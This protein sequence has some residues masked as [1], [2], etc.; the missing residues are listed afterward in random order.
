MVEYLENDMMILSSCVYAKHALTLL[1]NSVV[2]D[3]YGK[4]LVSYI[5]ND[6]P[7]ALNDISA[8]I[9]VAMSGSPPKSIFIITDFDADLI[10]ST[11]HKNIFSSKVKP[12]V[13]FLP[14]TARVGQLQKMLREAKTSIYEFEVGNDNI[15]MTRSEL[16][17]LQIFFSGDRNAIKDEYRSIKTFYSQK[18]SGLKK[19]RHTL[20]DSNFAHGEIIF[21]K[22]RLAYQKKENK[23]V[24]HIYSGKI[25]AVFV[26]VVNDSFN[27]E[28][29]DIELKLSDGK[30][31]KTSK[32][33]SY[34]TTFGA[35]ARFNAFVLGVALS[36]VNSDNGGVILSVPIIYNK[37]SSDSIVRIIKAVKERLLNKQWLGNIVLNIQL[38][39]NTLQDDTFTSE[40]CA[41]RS[42]GVKLEFTVER[43]S[44]NLFSGTMLDIYRLSFHLCG[45]DKGKNTA[46]NIDELRSMSFVLNF[47]NYSCVIKNIN[48]IDDFSKVNKFWSGLYQGDFISEIVNQ[49]GKR[50]S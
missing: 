41:I 5:S 10:G 23:I 44:N 1:L 24:D 13:L 28:S 7:N 29:Y 36:K 8:T 14:A 33:L 3:G 4:T 2:R 35:I 27:V 25:S 19:L 42:L 26:P 49:S 31:I 40:I 34:F 22:H 43:L 18:S 20:D 16:K 9:E 37:D 46:F 17:A 38:N 47:T 39:E 15:W 11:I 21:G 6:I 32:I 48:N 30:K 12:H 50:V 45:V